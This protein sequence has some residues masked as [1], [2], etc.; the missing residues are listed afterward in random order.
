MQIEALCGWLKPA[1]DKPKAF[2]KHVSYLQE[3]LKQWV[4]IHLDS[5]SYPSR[6]IKSLA[7]P[8]GSCVGVCCIC[9]Y[10]CVC[11]KSEKKADVLLQQKMS[12]VRCNHS[13][14]EVWRNENPFSFFTE[15]RFS[16]WSRVQKQHAYFKNLTL[17]KSK[18]SF[19]LLQ[20][21]VLGYLI[22]NVKVTNPEKNEL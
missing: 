13:H 18:Y 8:I 22:F 12:K 7:V 3:V 1:N 11:W 6:D 9:G 14:C 5:I 10:L 2:T 20:G 4:S 16:T 21:S 19:L 17:S 15:Y